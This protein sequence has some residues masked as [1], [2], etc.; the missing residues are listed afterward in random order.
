MRRLS[1]AS[2]LSLAL[3]LA[4]SEDPCTGHRCDSGAC[5]CGCECGNSSDPGV[6]Y[7]PKDGVV[8]HSGAASLPK[9]MRA[10][11]LEA[12]P[13]SAFGLNF[14]DAYPV[15]QPK[16]GEILIRVKASSVNPIDYKILEPA[17]RPAF[18]LHFPTVLGFE[19]AGIVAALGPG[20]VGR[21]KV[22]DE[23]WADMGIDYIGGYAD[24]AA[25][26]ERLL[27]I[28]PAKLSFTE[29]A[30]LPLVGMT[31]LQGLEKANALAPLEGQTVLILGG[32][33]GVGTVSVE[34]AKK[35]YKA[36]KVITTTS[37]ENAAFVRSLGADQVIDYHTSNWWEVV[38]NGTVDF[39]F[40]T[41]GQ[42]GTGPF[43]THKLRSGSGGV[44]LTI[45]H[46]GASVGMDANPPPNSVQIY[47]KLEYDAPGTLELLG[48]LVE[49]GELNAHL[50]RTYS[51]QDLKAAWETSS[52]G[53]VVGKLAIS[54]D[55]HEL[56][57]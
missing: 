24:Y 33:G 6:C 26:P 19:A 4:T 42:R 23:V 57:V 18:P 11:H 3:T 17:F 36:A 5:P 9:T 41:V 45:A 21:F 16:A 25:I 49:A 40:D 1:A 38:P 30:S 46:D 22:G 29:A 47:H 56:V 8:E 52:Q 53:H 48:K 27:A 31:S 44:F 7:V 35:H 20:T 54:L 51:L 14:T 2:L 32:S 12:Y 28:K 15:P 43:A 34:L 50:Q 55:D 39:V 13:S 37:A 10:W